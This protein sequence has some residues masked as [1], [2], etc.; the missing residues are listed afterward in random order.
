[1]KY[2]KG[3]HFRAGLFFIHIRRYADTPAVKRKLP[4]NLT[5]PIVIRQYAN[6]DNPQPG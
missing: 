4:G 1:M 5:T 6:C 3:L 2:L